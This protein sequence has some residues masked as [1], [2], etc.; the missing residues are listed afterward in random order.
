PQPFPGTPGVS[1]GQQLQADGQAYVDGVNKY[2]REAL[3]NPDLMP[4]E[5]PALQ[6]VP[7]FFKVTDVIAVATLVQ[8]IFATGGGNEIQSSLLYG[9]LV[10]QYGQQKGTAIWRDL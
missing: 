1:I 9:K 6:E 7:A 8:A 2:I 4:V 5:Y 10:Q 3:R